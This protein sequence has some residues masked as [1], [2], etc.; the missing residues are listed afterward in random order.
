MLFQ[1]FQVKAFICISAH[2]TSLSSSSSLTKPNLSLDANLFSSE[3]DS[4]PV[5]NQ[6][7]GTAPKHVATATS[8]G[9]GGGGLFDDEEDEDDDFFSGKSLKKPQPGKNLRTGS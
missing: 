7:N 5:V 3:N 6:E 8:A 9:G 1:Y 2:K 4:D